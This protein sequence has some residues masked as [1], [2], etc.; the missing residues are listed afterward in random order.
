M[1]PDDITRLLALLRSMEWSSSTPMYSEACCPEC[2]AIINEHDE[3][4]DGCELKA[5]IDRL[6][7]RLDLPARTT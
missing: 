4:D 3:H 1:T 6:E 2:R 7:V 5:W